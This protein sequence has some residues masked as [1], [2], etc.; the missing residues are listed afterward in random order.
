MHVMSPTARSW[1]RLQPSAQQ[2]VVQRHVGFA[3][4]QEVEKV[5]PVDAG[6]FCAEAFIK[7]EGLRGEGHK[8]DSRTHGQQ[9]LE[10]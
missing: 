9:E 8:S 3:P 4:P 5:A 2:Q 10:T 6:N 1:S 7:P